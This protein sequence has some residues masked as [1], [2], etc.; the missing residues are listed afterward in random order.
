MY[1]TLNSV[2]PVTFVF[3]ATNKI[4]I[5]KK[6]LVGCYMRISRFKT[7]ALRMSHCQHL[8][9]T[10]NSIDNNKCWDLRAHL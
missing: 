3:L 4:N 5:E 6:T 10:L 9:M 1:T 2:R 7:G 8:T